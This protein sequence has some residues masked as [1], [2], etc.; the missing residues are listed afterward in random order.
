[1]NSAFFLLLLI[2]FVSNP[3]LSSAAKSP[4]PVRDTNGK[5]VGAVARYYISPVYPITGGIELENLDDKPCPLDVVLADQ[6]PGLPVSFY[7]VK[8]KKGV[9]R[10]STDLNVEL[11]TTI[12]ST[13][14]PNSTMWSIDISPSTGNYFVSTG[15]QRGSPGPNTIINWFKIEPF[16]SGS[17]KLVYCP[18]FCKTCKVICKDV[19]IVVQNGKRRLGLTD[20]PMKFVL[21]NALK[22]F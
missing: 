17:Y 15:G 19:G 2:F 8:S 21:K 9:I 5:K 1:M 10:V 11:P 3:Q 6:V 22:G 4:D 7:S 14:C 18:T 20:D 12:P 16:G 13:I